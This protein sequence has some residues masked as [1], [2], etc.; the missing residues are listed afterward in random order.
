MVISALRKHYLKQ[1]N[2]HTFL[3]IFI[4]YR[5]NRPERNLLGESRFRLSLNDKR[6]T[7]CNYK[8]L[9][10]VLRVNLRLMLHLAFMHSLIKALRSSPFLPVASLLQVA[11]LF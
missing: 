2:K 9:I 3:A 5:E 8:G 1:P 4:D 11:I 6:K 7:P 10:S